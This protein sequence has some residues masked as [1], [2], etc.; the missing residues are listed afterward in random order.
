MRFKTFKLTW[1]RLK[2]WQ[3]HWK[4]KNENPNRLRQY[5]E[6]K[7][8]EIGYGR[9]IS[10][11]RISK[12]YFGIDPSPFLIDR[13]QQLHTS[14]RKKFIEGSAYA[15]PSS[16]CNFDAAFSILVWHLLGDIDR[17]AQELF[18]VLKDDG[19]FLIITAN[20]DGY[21]LWKSMDLNGRPSRDVLYLHTTEEI[22]TS[23][24]TNHLIIEHTE[25]FRKSSDE[26]SCYLIA[27]SGNKMSPRSHHGHL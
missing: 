18:R 20:P 3:K 24:K 10:S 2:P 12:D 16:D 15:I 22:N 8:L 21:D 13:A 14:P 9:G 26:S 7:V 25:I 17:A 6:H 23:F 5:D 4:I 27:F 1:F 19:K 11:S